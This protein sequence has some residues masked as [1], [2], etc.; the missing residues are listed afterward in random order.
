MIY[1]ERTKK[2]ME[3][4]LEAHANQV[5]RGGFPYCLHPIHL[6]EQMPDESSCIVALLHDVPEDCYGYNL[7]RVSERVGLTKEE[8]NALKLIT[9]I[10]SVPYMDYCLG[11][12]HNDIARRVKIADLEHNLDKTRLLGR[13]HRKEEIMCVCLQMLRESKPT[14]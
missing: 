1:T 5:D 10:K 7:K 8:E 14:S 2:A 3:L 11:L 4:C 6:A 9:H 13:P 12:A